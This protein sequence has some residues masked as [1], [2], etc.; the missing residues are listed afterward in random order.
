[1]STTQYLLNA[2]LLAFVLWT[3]LGTHIAT[4]ARLL[5]P[6]AMVAVAGWLFLGPI[7]SGGGDR[8]LVLVGGLAGVV[9]G[10]VA[11]L[12]VTVHADQD[13]TVTARA[14]WPYAALWTAVI[15]GRVL[16]ALGADHWFPVAVGRFSRDHQISGAAS[17]VTAFVL[18]A[19]CMVVARVGV[20]AART[21]RAH[22]RPSLALAA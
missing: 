2:A 14:G 13:G 7:P 20:T 10:V 17:W 3:N 18:M 6:L 9:L 4:R 22:R 16:F 15:G 19:L 5:A 12:L 21:L 1:M 11:G 8:D